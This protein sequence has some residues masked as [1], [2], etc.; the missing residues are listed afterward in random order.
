MTPLSLLIRVIA[1]SFKL[2]LPPLRVLLLISLLC[3]VRR[4]DGATLGVFGCHL[5]A[6][7]FNY[8]QMVC[9]Y[10]QVAPGRKKSTRD[11]FGYFSKIYS[12][13]HVLL[14]AAVMVIVRHLS[15]NDNL[16][17]KVQ[18][19]TRGISSFLHPG[20]INPLEKVGIPGKVSLF[21]F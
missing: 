16:G 18:K 10:R 4:A 8:V 7:G 20:M 11:S 21:D 19:K 6:Y 14:F 13:S 12:R 17:L 9:A 3:K 5:R 15:K 2:L 1:T